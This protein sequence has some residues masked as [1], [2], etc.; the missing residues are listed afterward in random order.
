[1]DSTSIQ[2]V[3]AND[4]TQSLARTKVLGGRLEQSGNAQRMNR[5]TR[6][7][8]SH[9]AKA[10]VG[11]QP[12]IGAG[13]NVSSMAQQTA[14]HESKKTGVSCAS[15]RSKA[16]PKGRCISMRLAEGCAP[17]VV[18]CLLLGNQ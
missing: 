4:N 2:V 13:N 12:Q 14:S 16:V 9:N 10:E 17:W 8:S 6:R 11:P 1:M 3:G 5:V 7:L 15:Q 18:A